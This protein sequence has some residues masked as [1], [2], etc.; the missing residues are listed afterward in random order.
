MDQN[1]QIFVEQNFC[2]N[3]H[4][5]NKD[6]KFNIIERIEKDKNMKS[7]IK[8]NKKQIDKKSENICVMWN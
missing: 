4:D 2:T 3:G 6:A 8:K 5:F 1:N 7:I